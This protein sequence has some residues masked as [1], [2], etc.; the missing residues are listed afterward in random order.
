MDVVKVKIDFTL[1]PFC[2]CEPRLFSHDPNPTAFNKTGYFADVAQTGRGIGV[3][4][5]TAVTGERARDSATFEG[6]G[7]RWVNRASGAPWGR[8]TT[9]SSLCTES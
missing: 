6:F 8:R 1:M 5:G 2:C 9:E 4:F 7:N 3:G